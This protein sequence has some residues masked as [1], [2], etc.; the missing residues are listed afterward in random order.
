MKIVR[1]IIIWSVVIAAGG[2]IG[3]EVFVT[4]KGRVLAEQRIQEELKRPVKIGEAHWMFPLGVIFKEVDIEGL[5][6]VKQAKAFFNVS[7]FQKGRFDIRHVII[8]Q[9]E[10]IVEQKGVKILIKDI[11]ADIRNLAYPLESLQ[12][13]VDVNGRLEGES[14]PLSGSRLIGQ[15]WVNLKKKDLLMQVRMKDVSGKEVLRSGLKALDNDMT[16]AGKVNLAGFVKQS[17]STQKMDDSMQ[18]LVFG[19]LGQ[20]GLDT[21]A[22]FSFQ[23]KM[24]AFKLEKISFS[25]KIGL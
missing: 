3:L 10:A 7:N 2:L 19:V 1:R 13:L 8:D 22:S 15:G 23:T 18:S 9:G 12:T 24:D 11:H 20:K 21:M 4:T 17:L 6:R 5:L 25:G 16:V 14:F